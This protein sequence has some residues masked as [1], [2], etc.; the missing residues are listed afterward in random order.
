MPIRL[1]LISFSCLSVFG[2]TTNSIIKPTSD[3]DISKKLM[4][5][6]EKIIAINQEESSDTNSFK[7]SKN[8]VD[9][10]APASIESSSNKNLSIENNESN[11]ESFQSPNLSDAPTNSGSNMTLE[12]TERTNALGNPLY[13]LKL[14]YPDGRVREFNTVTGRADTQNKKREQPGTQAPLP[15]GKYTVARQPIRATIPEAGKDFLPIQPLFRTRRTSLGIHYDPSFE[16]N[17]GEDGTSGCI[18]L[19]NR[20]DL[21]EVLN[22][23]QTYQPQYLQVQIK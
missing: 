23:V 18:G 7:S 10:S 22:Y 4:P 11:Q 15:D 19:T 3:I 12:R 16:K 9:D 1:A 2:C 6:T 5:S 14:F 17:N 13:L 20:E 21:E 8:I